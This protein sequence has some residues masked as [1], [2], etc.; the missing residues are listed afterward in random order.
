M[1]KRIEFDANSLLKLLVHYY[2]DHEDQ[3]PLDAELVHAGVSQFF[4]RWVMLEAKSDKW[5]GIH[6]APGWT[7]PY[8]LH[9]R[10]EGGKT[11]SWG[12]DSLAPI[13]WDDAVE[14]PKV[15]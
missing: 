5:S 10:Y 7:E 9:I 6:I 2:Q 1:Q 13:R 11:M 15:T 8:P 14:A 12:N 3:V 4:P